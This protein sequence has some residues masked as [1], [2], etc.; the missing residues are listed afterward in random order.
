[1]AKKHG[2]QAFPAPGFEVIGGGITVRDWFATF[3]P[4]PTVEEVNAEGE[5][6]K[7]ANPHG[8]SYKPKRRSSAEIRA[9]LLYRYADSMLAEREREVA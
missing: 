1:M 4:A 9:E 5:R 8:D 3:A 2:G 7:L 6:D